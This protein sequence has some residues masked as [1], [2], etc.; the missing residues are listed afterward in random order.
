MQVANGARLAVTFFCS[1]AKGYRYVLV[2]LG[3]VIRYRTFL[4]DMLDSAGPNTPPQW[5]DCL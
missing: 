2:D 5:A 4:Y 1:L 3:G